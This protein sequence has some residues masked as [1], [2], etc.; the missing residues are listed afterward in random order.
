MF[1]PACGRIV[2]SNQSGSLS[3]GEAKKVIIRG[4][5]RLV[6]ICFVAVSRPATCLVVTS[7]PRS[8]GIALPFL[9]VVKS[10]ASFCVG[11][12]L[13]A[14]SAVVT[15]I[16]RFYLSPAARLLDKAGRYRTARFQ[17]TDHR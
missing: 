14:M 10:K 2:D 7:S 15:G 16:R 6:F 12:L 11:F 3:I 4:Q 13:P 5:A 1:S 8:G 17:T 9:A